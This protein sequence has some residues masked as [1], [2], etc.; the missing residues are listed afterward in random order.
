MVIIYVVADLQMPVQ[1]VAAMKS[2]FA[3][4][5]LVL[6]VQVLLRRH[7]LRS[8]HPSQMLLHVTFQLE[9]GIADRASVLFDRIVSFNVSG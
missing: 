5:T 9:S 4:I 3:V 8:V 6:Q 2:H 1:M 7:V